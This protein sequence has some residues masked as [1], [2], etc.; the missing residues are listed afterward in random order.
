MHEKKRNEQWHHFKQ[1][2]VQV[3]MDI[4]LVLAAI[5]RNHKFP[6]KHVSEITNYTNRDF[7]D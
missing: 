3:L 2:A 4:N 1:E 5:K 7:M 6:N